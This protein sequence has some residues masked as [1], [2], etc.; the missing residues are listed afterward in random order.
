[1]PPFLGSEGYAEQGYPIDL[2][3]SPEGGGDMFIQDVIKPI[4]NYTATHPREKFCS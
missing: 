4:P 1:M 2:F 3:I